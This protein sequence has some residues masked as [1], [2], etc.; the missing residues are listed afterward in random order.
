MVQPSEKEFMVTTAPERH[1]FGSQGF[2][3]S[4]INHELCHH[5]DD[6]THNR[7]STTATW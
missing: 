4:N 5:T 1:V 6:T 7:G 3:H 2:S